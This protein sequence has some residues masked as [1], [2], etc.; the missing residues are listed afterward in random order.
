MSEKKKK[1]GYIPPRRRI[2]DQFPCPIC[3]ERRFKWGL[4][5]KGPSVVEV[6]ISWLGEGIIS[7]T[8]RECMICGNVQFFTNR[9]AK[10]GVPKNM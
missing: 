1:R 7:T 5:H 9:G 6:N 8:A 10:F 3:G 2:P 4:A